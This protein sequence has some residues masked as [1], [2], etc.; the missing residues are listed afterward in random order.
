MTVMINDEILA[1]VTG[2]DNNDLQWE[3][4]HGTPLY[5]VGES[6]ERYL[7]IFHITTKAGVILDR[8][9]VTTSSGRTYWYYLFH[10][11]DFE[12]FNDVWVT[13][14]DIERK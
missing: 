10:H 7:S 1:K 11:T 4:E 2:G 12:L 6:V 3:K 8:H 9:P 5:S 14:N 13:A